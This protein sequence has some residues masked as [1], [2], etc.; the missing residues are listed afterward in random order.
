MV[1]VDCS[2]LTPTL[3]HS[4]LFGH[5]RGAFTGAISDHKGLIEQASGGT[6]YL[7]E[8]GDM[9][10]DLQ[11]LLLRTI[12][13]KRI[14]R[15]GAP[16]DTI[17]DIRLLAATHSPH[18][19]R[20]DLYH[21]LGEYIIH[22]PPLRERPED[23]PRLARGFGGNTAISDSAMNCLQAWSWPGNIRELQHTIR[24]ALVLADGDITERDILIYPPLDTPT[25]DAGAQ[26]EHLRAA[27]Y[28]T[29]RNLITRTL[30][31]CG[32]N[33]TRAA[34]ELKIARGTL[35]DRMRKY[36]LIRPRGSQEGEAEKE[37]TR[38]G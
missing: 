26:Q 29:E 33:Q 4:E 36:G 23:I 7:D 21:R 37:E 17:V 14:R 1:T 11:T 22:I 15:V 16:H 10:A 20:P 32:W 6:L 35:S 31:N 2:A 12:E 8:I 9:A 27:V 5:T 3:A 24:R 13:E 38:E 19:L 25:S 18:L 34:K 28:D 30:H